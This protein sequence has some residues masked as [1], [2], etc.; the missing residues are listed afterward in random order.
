MRY[1][2]LL[3]IVVGALLAPAYQSMD[4]HGA[5]HPEAQVSEV[6]DQWAKAWNDKDPKALLALYD[7]SAILIPPTGER[8]SGRD[9]I[10][11]YLTEAMKDSSNL[12]FSN[13]QTDHS[14]KLVNDSGSLQHTITRMPTLKFGP[15]TVLKLGAGTVF[16]IGPVSRQ[17]EGTYVMLLKREPKSKLLIVE[18]TWNE[19]TAA[20]VAK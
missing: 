6:R 7:D 11:N 9:N 19:T 16:K 1:R 13:L 12:T 20:P 2:S 10:E 18:H 15:G 3:F 17:V 4:A 14:G 8:I 5:S